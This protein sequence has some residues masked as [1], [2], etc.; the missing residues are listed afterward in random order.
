MTALNLVHHTLI[1]CHKV[2]N[3]TFVGHQNIGSDCFPH[4]WIFTSYFRLTSRFTNMAFNKPVSFPP[5]SLHFNLM[6]S[7]HLPLHL[8]LH[9]NL[10]YFCF[11]LILPGWD[12]VRSALRFG[13]NNS[14]APMPCGCKTGLTA[15]PPI[16]VLDLEMWNV[17]MTCYVDKEFVPSFFVERVGHTGT[18][19]KYSEMLF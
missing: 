14:K 19:K 12:H 18:I 5:Y 9:L 6:V 10:N 13:L 16:T 7:A 17:A 2:Q 1:F 15:N 8:N 3:E 4:G 11:D